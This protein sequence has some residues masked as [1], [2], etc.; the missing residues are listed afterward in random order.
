MHSPYMLNNL[1]NKCLHTEQKFYPKYQT[2]ADYILEAA[3]LLTDMISL[4]DDRFKQEEVYEKIKEIETQCDALGTEIYSLL[5]DAYY[6]PLDRTDMHNLCDGLDDVLDFI[7]SSSKR[8]MLY[9]PKTMSNQTMH[10]AELVIEC[11]K[12]IQ[13]AMAELPNI[14]RHPQ[15]ALEQ[16]RQLHDLEHEGDDV[17][18]EFVHALFEQETDARELIKIKEIMGCLETATDCANRVG[19]VLKLAIVK[20]K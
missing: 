4:E 1:L 11:A 16:C 3:N 5:N 2:M 6:T 14:K 19:K 18:G 10:M 12:C 13:V 8:M 15:V 7:E 9:Q 17:Y 20:Y